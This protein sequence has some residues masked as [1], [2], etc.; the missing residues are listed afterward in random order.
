MGI[1]SEY[2]VTRRSRSIGGPV[3]ITPRNIEA[4]IRLAEASARM[5][6]KDKVT[7]DD[8]NAAIRIVKHY[9]ETAAATGEEGIYDIDV[10][11]TGFTTSQRDRIWAILDIIKE[12]QGTTGVSRDNIV[13]IA[14]ERGIAAAQVEADLDRLKRDGRI[15]QKYGE[16][17]M[18]P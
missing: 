7:A 5:K 2:Y 13:S 9:I 11:S 16:N 1:M 14:V 12:N 17:Y 4:M 18:I 8:A 3:L 6:L 15:Y 10:I